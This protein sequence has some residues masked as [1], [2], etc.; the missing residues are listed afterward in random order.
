ML[1]SKLLSDSNFRLLTSLPPPTPSLD[2]TRAFESPSVPLTLLTRPTTPVPLAMKLDVQVA[3]LSLLAAVPQSL[4]YRLRSKLSVSHTCDAE[5]D[6]TMRGDSGV[7]GGEGWDH[8]GAGSRH[9]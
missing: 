5:M 4:A 6:G 3:L 7:G 1:K 2:E 9:G 8:D